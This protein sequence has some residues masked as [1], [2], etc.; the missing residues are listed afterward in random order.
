M[1]PEPWSVVV[2]G[3]CNKKATYQLEDILK[4]QTLEERIYRHRCVEALV[5]GDSMGR[6]PAREFHQAL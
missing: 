1:K 5:D 4:G 2:D 6:V 3:E